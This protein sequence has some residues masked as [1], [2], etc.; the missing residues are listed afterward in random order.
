ME[1]GHYA[2][3]AVGFVWFLGRDVHGGVTYP[4]LVVPPQ[5]HRFRPLTV[6]LVK[7]G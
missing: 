4:R 2:P 5:S 3:Y 6:V 7:T 1:L